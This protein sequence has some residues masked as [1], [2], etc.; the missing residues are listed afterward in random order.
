[1][2]IY[3]E[4][5]EHAMAIGFTT[6]STAQVGPTAALPHCL[7]QPPRSAA[8]MQVCVLLVGGLHASA[9]LHHVWPC[10]ALNAAPAS[11]STPALLR[12]AWLPALCRCRSKTRA[13]A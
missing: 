8:A 11:V 2:A 5:K 10:L 9:A 6:M 1:M 12:L 3:A 13:S 7:R 4:G